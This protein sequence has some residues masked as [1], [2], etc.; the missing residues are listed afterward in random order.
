MIPNAA[1]DL[2]LKI[3]KLSLFRLEQEMDITSSEPY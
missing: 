1:Q 3:G 2:L